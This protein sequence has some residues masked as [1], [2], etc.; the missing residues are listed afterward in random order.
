MPFIQ[1][2]SRTEHTSSSGIEITRDF[3]CKPYDDYKVVTRKLQGTVAKNDEGKWERTPPERDSYIE[4]C[5]CNENVVKFAHPDAMASSENIE[6]I[7]HLHDTPENLATGAAGAIITAHYR[8]LVTAWVQGDLKDNQFDDKQIWDWLDPVFKP[9][10]R[11]L[12]WPDGLFITES[13]AG[14]KHARGVPES[15][16]TPFAVPVVDISIRRTLVGEVPLKVIGGLSGAVNDQDFPAAGAARNGLGMFK[17][18][19]LK[20]EGTDVKNMFDADGY[21]WVELTNHFKWCP[22]EAAKRFDMKGIE[23]GPGPVTWNHVF[24]HPSTCDFQGPTG[25]YEVWRAEQEDQIFGKLLD[26]VL[27]GSA[28]LIRQA[29]GKLFSEGNLM[30]LFEL[31]P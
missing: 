25:W 18:R 4:N 30:R 22:L 7:N 5:Y 19:T 31:N 10:V 9:G 14:R 11:F 3:Y 21:P 28:N 1:Q 27:P 2:L 15:L 29:S 20:Y 26:F 16:A 17:A 12:P 24:L 6:T 8:P 23:Q 13:T